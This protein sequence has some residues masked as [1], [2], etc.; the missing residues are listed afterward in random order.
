MRWCDVPSHH[1]G[2]VWVKEGLL[3]SFVISAGWSF[4]L[5]LGCVSVWLCPLVFYFLFICSVY[6]FFLLLLFFLSA[7]LTCTQ[8][9]HF[10]FLHF[11]LLWG[12]KWVFVCVTKGQ[13][14][15]EVVC[16]N[17]KIP[18]REAECAGNGIMLLWSSFAPLSR[19]RESVQVWLC[20][21][22]CPASSTHRASFPAFGILSCR[23]P[24]C[25]LMKW[26]NITLE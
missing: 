20:S 19:A 16:C 17:N 18:C 13:S 7:L 8:V 2:S 22:P 3:L 4:L 26:Q 11:I 15:S 25:V 9:L 10:L 6:I 21:C 1:S 24:W 12:F 14:S 23:R 5:S